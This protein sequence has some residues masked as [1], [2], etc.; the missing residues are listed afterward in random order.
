MVIISN[1]PEDETNAVANMAEIGIE[2]A[3]L[4]FSTFDSHNV[5]VELVRREG[6][7]IPGLTGLDKLKKKW[8]AHNG[9]SWPGYE[10]ARAMSLPGSEQF[11][12]DLNTLWYRRFAG[13]MPPAG[14]SKNRP[15]ELDAVNA[16]YV[17]NAD[18]LDT[19]RPRQG[20]GID[21]ARSGDRT[22]QIDERKGVLEVAYSEPGTNHT[23]QFE[24]IWANLDA[25]PGAQISGDAVGEGS[26]KIDDTAARY[27]VVDRFKNGATAVQD[28]D[29]KDR[30][31]EGLCELGKWL[32][33]GGEYTDSRL[34]KELQIAA[35]TL[36]LEERYY[37]SHGD[38]VYVA[39]PK[40]KVEERLGHSPDHLDA[41]IMAV[42][43]AEGLLPEEDDGPSGSGT[44]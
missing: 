25:E 5:Q 15:I 44:W 34:R 3:K 28:G 40:A 38:Q 20:T 29:Y 22:V 14:A 43:A 9:E 10:A 7:W 35:R 17:E 36:T 13:I 19:N 27:P 41:A 42:S 24:R 30:W 26:G 23:V 37:K 31:T 2:P 32:E 33:R 18:D 4:S 21:V 6:E 16:G 11:R 8:E 1:P 39:D 12:K